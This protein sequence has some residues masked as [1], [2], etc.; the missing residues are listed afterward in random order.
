[1][2]W[3]DYSF[4]NSIKSRMLTYI[5]WCKFEKWYANRLEWVQEIVN[6]IIFSYDTHSQFVLS[7]VDLKFR[8]NFWI[9]DVIDYEACRTLSETQ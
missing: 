4:T 8:Q 9:Y 1:M 2:R 6:I 7:F 5:D 3:F